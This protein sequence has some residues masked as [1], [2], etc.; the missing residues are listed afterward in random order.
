MQAG[1]RIGGQTVQVTLY[2]IDRRDVRARRSC[3]VCCDLAHRESRD[4]VSEKLLC[5]R[6]H[7]PGS[8]Y[9]PFTSLVYALDHI[10]DLW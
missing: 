5:Q 4:G 9:K 8:A 10:Q 3:H 6:L 2:A 7:S 1:T